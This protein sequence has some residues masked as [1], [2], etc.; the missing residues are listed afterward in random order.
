MSSP[1]ERIEN[2]VQR[3]LK[4]QQKLELSTLRM[5]LNAIKNEQIRIG[6]EVDES[7]FVNLVRRAIKQRRESI[8]QYRHGGREDL[9]EKETHEAEILQRY[10]PPQA[11]E[12]EIRSA[13]QELIDRESLTGP[14]SLGS[15][16]QE[17]MKRFAGTADGATINRIAR[18]I[19]ADG[20]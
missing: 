1:R 4:A 8:E 11:G 15:V 3:A 2:D 7:S 12:E 10:L 16:M 5:L 6:S 14:Q 20:S 17:M 18:E 13:I 9:V 19:L